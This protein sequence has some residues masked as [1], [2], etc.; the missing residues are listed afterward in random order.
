MWYEK[1]EWAGKINQNKKIHAHNTRLENL[2]GLKNCESLQYVD[3]ANAY[4]TDISGLSN[5]SKLKQVV[6]NVNRRLTDISSLS[7]CSSLNA[8]LMID[9]NGIMDWSPLQNIPVL[10]DV[11]MYRASKKSNAQQVHDVLKARGIGYGIYD[12]LIYDSASDGVP[13]NLDTI[14]CNE[15]WDRERYSADVYG[16]NYPCKCSYCENWRKIGG[17]W[18]AVKGAIQAQV[19]L[20]TYQE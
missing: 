12:S 6:L 19:D 2:D 15:Y 7:T 11:A 3:V 17:N 16:I 5:K 18:T 10:K 13:H 14:N 4:L 9:C 8:V 20:G 1:L